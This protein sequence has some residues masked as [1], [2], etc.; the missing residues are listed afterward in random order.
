M[1]PSDVICSRQ[2]ARSDRQQELSKTEWQ[3]R[4]EE[5]DIA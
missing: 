5:V 1:D 4:F 2:L 3:V